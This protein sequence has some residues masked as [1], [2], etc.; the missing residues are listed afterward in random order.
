MEWGSEAY[1]VMKQIK[2]IFDP[3]GIFNP[4]VILND[5][6]NTFI[7]NLKPMPVAHPIIDQ[8]IEC[9]F[10]EKNCPSRELT[11]SPRQRIVIWREI[12][13]LE[14]QGKDPERL[15]KLKQSYE[16]MGN[17][18]CAAD[19]MCATSCPVSIDTG[20]CLSKNFEQ[21]ISLNFQN[22]LQIRLLLILD[23]SLP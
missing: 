12:S 17:S 8:C 20:K 16:Y 22:K 19:G 21:I 18:T 7:K 6:P 15:A 9:G 23:Y 10:C 14:A 4:G 3:K 2:A 11:L 1:Q 5:D 13:R